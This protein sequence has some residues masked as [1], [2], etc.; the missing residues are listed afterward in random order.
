ME[1]LVST[2]A[3][4]RKLSQA[5]ELFLSGRFSEA[6]AL[7]RELCRTGHYPDQSRFRLGQIARRQDRFSEAA[8]WLTQALAV[9]NMWPD[10]HYE[11]ALA[12]LAA[13]NPREAI[14]GL[15]KAL[16]QDSAHVGARRTL[17]DLLQAA[18]HWRDAA[19]N[20]AELLPLQPNDP[21]LY[22]N[23]GLCCQELG[24]Y[25]VAEKAYLKTLYFGTESPELRFNLGVVQL[26]QG[27]PG[28][29]IASL[30]SALKLDP[31]LTLANLAM[32]NA[33]RQL[34][35]LSSAEGSLRRELAI[36]PNCADAAVNLGVV[37]QERH[38]VREA[39]HCYKQAIQLNPHHPILHWNYA[40]A[41]L[42]AGD[43]ETGWHEYEW[44]WQVKHKPKPKY[45]QPEWDGSDLQGR[46]VLLYAEQ[47]FGDTLMFIRYAPL[48]RRRNGR[49]ILECQP[50]LKR[51][52]GA[53]PD[54][55]QVVSFGEPLPQFHLQAPLMSLPRIFGPALDADHRWEPYLRSAQ[56]VE[57]LLPAHDPDKFK[58]GVVWASNPQHPIFSEKSLDLGKWEPVL[59]V[60]GCEFFSLQVDPNPTAVSFVRD[61]PHVHSLHPRFSDFADTAAAIRQLDLVISVDTSVAH[62]AGGLGHLVWV[63]LAFS[64][65]WRW[66]LKRKD[67]PWYP[68][69]SLFRQPR[70]GDWESVVAE[71]AR[72]LAELAS[73]R[74]RDHRPRS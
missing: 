56:D 74:D 33:Y 31:A 40:I 63:L 69:M 52:L 42:L 67:S 11:L 2:E 24:E 30:Q 48:V 29:A 71:V 19:Q 35:D 39:I 7:Y 4:K 66:L 27:R 58:V 51:L 8:D 72:H 28:E 36:N 6:D 55:S 10:A 9:R 54:I 20:Y 44:R 23:F 12:H 64:A 41:S 46:T 13:Q 5:E 21:S 18:S 59:N 16:A 68:T 34:G 26:K 25:Q 70:P 60:P 37:L 49:V 1:S 53:M 61:H 38:R 22:Q 65:D 15:Q 43:Y 3:N 14:A 17:A 57:W 32:A 45:S 50:P 47:G 73:R 62:L